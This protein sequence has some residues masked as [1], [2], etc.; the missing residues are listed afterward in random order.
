MKTFPDHFLWGAAA[1]APQTEGAA[2]IDGKSA[3][4]W[5][6][7][8]EMNPEKFAGH[9]G[10]KD[11]SNVYEQYLEDVQLMEDMNLNSYRTSI[12]WARLLPDG[13]T[14]NQKAV[15]FYRNYFVSMIEK[16]VEPIVNLFHFDMPWWLM[17]KGGWESRE[18]VEAFGYYAK[19]AFEQFGDLVQNWT[20]FNEP[21]VHVECGYLFE[22]HYPAVVDFK[23]AVQVGYHTV[24]AHVQA[25]EEFRKSGHKG[26]V[27]IILNLTPIFSKSN[28]PGDIAAKEAADELIVK[29]FL[30]PVVLGRVSPKLIELLKENDLLPVTQEGDKKR[31]AQ[32]TIDF[33]GVNYY[34]PKR[35]QAVEN[36]TKPALMPS[37]LYADYDWPDKKINPYRGWEIYPAALYD[38][39]MRIKDEYGNIPWYVSENGMGVAEEERFMNEEGII[40]DDYRIEFVHDHLLELHKAIEQGSSCFGYHMW[41]FIDCWSWLN[42]YRNRYGFYRVDIVDG[43]KRIPK[44]SSFWMKDVSQKN[45]IHEGVE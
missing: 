29:S 35:V 20:T 12:S 36:P 22:F 32:A 23:R 43:F 2:S 11:T 24:M 30:D 10:P 17:E 33:L 21:I 18:S 28:A 44:K 25:V 1:S 15:D 5:D 4:T 40:Q 9:I 8:F 31:I 41:T 42:G 13:K 14:L 38:I 3:T 34:Q 39:A 45:A 6:K 16:G 7:W 27:G 37:D 19:V 26:E